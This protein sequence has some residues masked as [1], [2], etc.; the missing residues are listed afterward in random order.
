MTLI[1][2]IDWPNVFAGAL[3]AGALGAIG[4]CIKSIILHYSAKRSI[5]RY[6]QG[7]WFSAEY[8]PKGNVPREHRTTYLRVVMEPTW[9]G[10]VRIRSIEQLRQHPSKVE[11]GWIAEAR[12]ENGSLLG[13]WRTTVK[14]TVRFG[15]AMIRFLDNGRAVG[16]WIGT[17]GS[18]PL[19][20]GYWIMSKSEDDLR[21][22]IAGAV[23]P[24]SFKMIDVGR[25]V[26]DFER[27]TRGSRV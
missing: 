22:V 1:S 3:V 18:D 7:E 14:G 16:Y 10:R 24:G 19:M 27:G 4:F 2:S 12:I 8:D 20:Y 25:R 17:R 15:C 26:A 13:E 5:V 23:P 21:A 9:R 6:G 11:T